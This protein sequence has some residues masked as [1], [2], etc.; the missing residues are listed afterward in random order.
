VQCC[1]DM[2]TSEFQ[3]V[4]ILPRRQSLR[5]ILDEANGCARSKSW[6]AECSQDAPCLL[7]AVRD[8]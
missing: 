3:A 2:T 6:Q 5:K 1:Y 8:P 4:W 7:P